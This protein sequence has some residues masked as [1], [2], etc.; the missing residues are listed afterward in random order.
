MDQS[1]MD[2]GPIAVLAE[3]PA[4]TGV[5]WIG[6]IAG[7][8]LVALSALLGAGSH[9]GAADAAGDAPL[10][11]DGSAGVDAGAHVEAVHVDSGGMHLADWFSMRFL[12]YFAAAFGLVGTTLSYLSDLRPAVVLVAAL[13]AGLFVGQLV[14]QT[15]RYLKRSSSDSSTKIADYVNKLG[16]VTIAIRPPRIG[17]VAVQIGEQERFLAATARRPDDTFEIGAEVGVVEFRNGISV[18]VSK[19]EFDFSQEL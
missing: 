2:I 13:L 12:I 5:Y 17:E 10:D 4:L 6:L 11:F 18:V 3:W 1:L 9:S 16:R 19:K 8:G 15:V 7:G 14:H